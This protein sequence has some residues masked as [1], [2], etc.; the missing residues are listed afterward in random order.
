MSVGPPETERVDGDEASVE[1]RGLCD[2]LECAVKQAWDVGVGRVEVQVWG[3][4]SRV[5]DD[6]TLGDPGKSWAGLDYME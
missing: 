1:G 3:D 4:G 5:H 2:D 6:H